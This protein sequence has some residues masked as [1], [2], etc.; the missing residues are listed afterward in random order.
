MMQ[1]ALVF[2][3]VFG[4]LAGLASGTT[5]ALSGVPA[6]SGM[7]LIKLSEDMAKYK[8][9]TAG[10]DEANIR[11]FVTKLAEGM[12]KYKLE[13]AGLD[14]VFSEAFVTALLEGN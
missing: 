13:T 10:L 2:G 5:T 12:A 7:R 6:I 8:P 4:L 9:E 1:L 3:I 14:K 11:A